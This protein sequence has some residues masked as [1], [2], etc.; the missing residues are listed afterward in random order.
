MKLRTALG[1]ALAGIVSC[2]LGAQSAG[3]QLE[4][5][6]ASVKL[7]DPQSNGPIGVFTAPGGRLTIRHYS[8]KMLICK[9]YTVR[10]SEVSG[11]QR[12][13][14]STTFDI[15]AKATAAFDTAETSSSNPKAPPSSGI[16]TMLQNLLADRFALK[17]HWEEQQ[18]SVFA[19]VE[20]KGGAKLKVT[21]DPGRDP[22]WEFS[23]GVIGARNRSIPWLAE[24]LARITHHP[25]LDQTGLR[26]TYDFV[27]S[28]DESEIEETRASGETG[29]GS[30]LFTALQ[31]QLGLK[32][33]PQKGPVRVLVIDD[34]AKPSAN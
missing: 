6:V 3:S 30:S 14:D 12:W 19:L 8:L 4:F 25:V 18:R 31:D 11:G 23:A 15:D 5:D 7:T 10:E 21:Q 28:W 32:L 34:A 29:E 16:L 17:V 20:A 22:W 9:A 2:G 24:Q 13:M 27:L 33:A 26:G 1:I